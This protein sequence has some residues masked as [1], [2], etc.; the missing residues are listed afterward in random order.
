MHQRRR[1]TACLKNIMVGRCRRVLYVRIRRTQASR[2]LKQGGVQNARTIKLFAYSGQITGQGKAAV[3][4]MLTMPEEVMEKEYGNRKRITRAFPAAITGSRTP[5]LSVF[6]RQALILH[7][8]DRF[9]SVCF[10]VKRMET[11]VTFLRRHVPVRPTADAIRP[12]GRNG[13]SSRALPASHRS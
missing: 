10:T 7:N 8:P 1:C 5:A 12:A 13:G 2:A 9:E 3:P 11:A 6:F 4:M